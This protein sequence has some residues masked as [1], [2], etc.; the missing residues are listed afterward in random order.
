MKSKSNWRPRLKQMFVVA[1]VTPTTWAVAFA[2][3]IIPGAVFTTQAAAVLYAFI[4]A[5]GAGLDG[6]SVKILEGA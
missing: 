2:R 1:P 5:S 6:S 3:Q 4:L